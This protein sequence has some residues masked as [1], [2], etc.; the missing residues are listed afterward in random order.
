MPILERYT[1]QPAER[2]Y[3]DISFAK[4]LLTHGDAA[5]PDD[6]IEAQVATGIVMDEVEWFNDGG[7]V[8]LWFTGGTDRT[9][10]LASARL[11]TIK[12]EILE[13]DIIVRVRE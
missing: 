2:K 4:Y 10:Y 5:I 3:F 11:S 6:P 8:R 13:G 9:D 7:F 1:K 12:G